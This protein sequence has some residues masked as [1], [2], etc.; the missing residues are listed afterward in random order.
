MLAGDGDTLKVISIR[1][2]WAHFIVMGWKQIENRNWATKYRGPVLVHAS[3]GMTR[4]EYADACD[5]A[6]IDC[7]IAPSLLPA[8]EELQR[9][10]IVGMAE[11]TGCVIDSPDPWFFGTVGHVLAN[12]QQLSFIPLKGQLGYFDVSKLILQPHGDM[13]PLPSESV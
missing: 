11:V 2:P 8:F 6:V 13:S 3:K 12:A 9:G 4:A 7:G 1:Q 10:G 5:C